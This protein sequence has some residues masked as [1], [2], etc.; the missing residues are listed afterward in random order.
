MFKHK[1]K[2]IFFIT[3]V[4]SDIFIKIENKIAKLTFFSFRKILNFIK[5]VE[6]YYKL[7]CSIPNFV[8][9]IVDQ[10]S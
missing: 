4:F 3:N 9:L 8:Q 2:S 7:Y 6:F 1:R 10:I 5:V